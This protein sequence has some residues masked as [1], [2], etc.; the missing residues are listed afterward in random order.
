MVGTTPVTEV[1][2][3]IVSGPVGHYRCPPDATLLLA[4]TC[5]DDRDSKILAYVCYHRVS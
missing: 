2:I 3:A 4:A 1:A 5:P